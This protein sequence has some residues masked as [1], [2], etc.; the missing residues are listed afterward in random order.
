MFNKDF[1]NR[2]EWMVKME[3]DIDNMISM[4]IRSKLKLKVYED[5]PDYTFMSIIH[6]KDNHITTF[7][8]RVNIEHPFILKVDLV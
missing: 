1:I 4:A 3:K 5:V 8:V 6:D 7:N 2:P